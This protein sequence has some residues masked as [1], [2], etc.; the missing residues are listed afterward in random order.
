[1]SVR[2]PAS[3]A[4]ALPPTWT[5]AEVLLSSANDG[6][7]TGSLARDAA[8]LAKCIAFFKGQR[9]GAKIVLM[10]HS[11]G[12]QDIMEYLTGS[13]QYSDVVDGAIL[14][15]GVSDRQGWDALVADDA[16]LAESLKATV[17][18]ARKLVES[19]DGDVILPKKG[20][21]VLEM[22]ESPCTAY[23]ADSLFSFG[24][25]DD[26]F[27]TDLPEEKLR[28][29]FGKVPRG[30]KMMFLWGS[31]DPYIPA[32]VDQE[33]TLKMWA[34][35]VKEGGG[36]VDEVNG[37]VVQGATHNLNRDDV[38]VVQDLVGRVVRFVEGL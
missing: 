26:Y 10:G 28:G 34:R 7:G 17:K 21:R 23:R 18:L 11:T 38:E 24:G 33:G 19:G 35:Y 9:P 8:E 27:S 2:Y 32:D 22:F 29:T 1:M 37:G 13:T 12:C 20:S 36:A 5:I 4:K 30:T 25:D 16:E 3:I 6:W 15:A 31:K 14:Q